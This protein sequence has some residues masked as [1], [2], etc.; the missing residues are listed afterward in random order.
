MAKHKY[1]VLPDNVS[2]NGKRQ[3][4]IVSLDDEK[5]NIQALIDGGIV[6]PVTK[7]KEKKEE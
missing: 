3:G 2:V 7:P 4:E 1:R 5:Y 6:K